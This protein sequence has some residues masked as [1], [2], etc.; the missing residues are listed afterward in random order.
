MSPCNPSIRYRLVLSDYASRLSYQF[1]YNTIK[2]LLKVTS[3]ELRI[4]PLVDMSGNYYEHLQQLK[5]DLLLDGYTCE[6]SSVSYEFQKKCKSS[7][8]N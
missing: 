6:E 7:Y 5:K 3:Q 1:H 4:F 8:E 2:E